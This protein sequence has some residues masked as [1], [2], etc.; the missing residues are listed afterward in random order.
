MFTRS[1]DQALPSNVFLEILS[2]ETQTKLIHWSTKLQKRKL[3][4]RWM[5]SEDRTT[6][7][8]E[9]H[10]YTGIVYQIP[11]VLPKF[12]RCNWQSYMLFYEYIAT[13]WKSVFYAERWFRG[14][15]ILFFNGFC[16]T[17]F[18]FR[19]W[20]SVALFCGLVQLYVQNTESKCY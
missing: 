2:K 11:I 17:H 16:D 1:N 6:F 19:W 5:K 20:L 10:F 8:F 4:C 3:G 12:V 13:V 15:V 18:F 14:F 7:C 9:Y